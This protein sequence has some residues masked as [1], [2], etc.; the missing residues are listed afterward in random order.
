MCF[1]GIDV[2]GTAI[3]AGLVSKDGTIL[4][5]T[6]C[7]T[8]PTRTA[9]EIA[10]DIAAL[11]AALCASKAQVESIGIGIPGACDDKNGII[12]H[13]ANLP[14]CNFPLRATVEAKVPLPVYLGNDANCAALGEYSMLREK[15]QSMVFLTLGTGIGG[16]MILDGKLYKGAGGMAGE[17][18]HILL[19]KDGEPCNCGR[20]GCYEAY[21][22]VTAL[23]RQT[24]AFLKVHPESDFKKAVGEDYATVNG[25]TAFAFMKTGNDDAR[26][27]VDT[28]LGYVGDGIVD[29]INILEPELFMIGGAISREGDVLLKPIRAKVER[30]A[31]SKGKPYPKL[32]IAA[33][34]ND[35]GIIGAAFLGRMI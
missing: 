7:P 27:I 18:G 6:T 21:A 26:K 17:V 2:G 22:S 9:A 34:G 13:T 28:W 20:Y 16:G 19:R 24:V 14:F 30:E 32:Q 10:E 33:L 11:A 4:K 8:L 5:R 35:A 25:E 31:F 29:L 3:K 23:I 12:L 1:V 15:V